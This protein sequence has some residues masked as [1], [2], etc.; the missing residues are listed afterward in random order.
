MSFSID[1]KKEILNQEFNK[2]QAN[3]FISGLIISS[4]EIF[5]ESIIIKLNNNFISKEVRELLFQLNIKNLT[6]KK[7]KN[8]IEINNNDFE[9]SPTIK[10]P[11]Y[12]FA[13]IFVGGGSVSDPNTTSYHLEIQF[14]YKEQAKKVVDYL[15]KYNFSFTII[16]RRMNWVIYLKKAD[17]I[18]DFLKA[19]QA[20]NSLII[21]EDIRIQRDYSNHLNRYSNLDSHNQEKLSIASSYHLENYKYIINNNLKDKFNKNEL[22]FFELKKQNPFSSLA[23]LVI[24]LEEKGIKKTRSG[25]NHWLIKL[26]KIVEE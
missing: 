15:Y 12:Y 25:L 23:E 16:K 8:W 26:R 18:S 13:G 9:I 19:I 14:Y 3:A 6:N 24:L 11:G 10:Q 4:A 17:M 5:K 22:I 2:E 7:N 21:F 1:V 20:T